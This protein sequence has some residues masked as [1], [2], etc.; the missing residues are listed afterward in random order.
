MRVRALEL[1]L[2][3]DAAGDRFPRATRKQRVGLRMSTQEISE[4]CD[5]LNGWLRETVATA[6]ELPLGSQRVARISKSISHMPI[7][8]PS[9][10]S[11]SMH[12]GFGYKLQPD[13]QATSLV[14]T[15]KPLALRL[16]LTLHLSPHLSLP[17]KKLLLN[18]SNLPTLSW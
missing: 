2:L 11:P 6:S 13:L 7:H 17:Q 3:W 18:D 16:T 4:Q 15:N 1:S 12:Y 8:N 14:P 10:I 5:G 9:A